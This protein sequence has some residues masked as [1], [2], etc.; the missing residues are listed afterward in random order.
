MS[1]I[2]KEIPNTNG[3]YFA[4]TDGEIKSAPRMRKYLS[5]GCVKGE[6]LRD[7]RILKKVKSEH[8]YYCV[9]LKLNDGTQKTKMVHRLVAQTFIP[10]PENKPQINHID[11]C[12]TNNNISNLEWCTAREN[13]IHAFKNGLNLGSKPWLGKCGKK[14]H[15]SIPIVA[16]DL[17]GNFVREY[18]SGNLAAKD[19]GVTS[20]HISACI[21]GKRKSAYGFIWK[22]KH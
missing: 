15:N 18:E 12:K 1:K 7:G 14:H 3:L 19:L 21:H 10:N 16:Y 2:W 11:G 4:S 8:G 20:S 13:I 17:D 5:G 6:Y 22:I 9:T